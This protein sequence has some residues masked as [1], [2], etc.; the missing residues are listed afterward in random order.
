MKKILLATDGSSCAE[1]AACFLAHLPHDEQLELTVLTVLEIPHTHRSSLTQTWV[2]ECLEQ[3][4]AASAE[5]F[6]QIEEMF[7]GANATLQHVVQEGYR[8]ET[9]VEVAKEADVSLV[10]VGA[11]GHSTV[12]R[13]LLGS[14]SDYVATH[15]HCSVLV[16]RPTGVCKAKRPV[17]L[18]I[19]YAK[20]APAQA[21]L[22]EIAEIPWGKETDVQ[23]ISVVSYLAATFSHIPVDAHLLKNATATAVEEAAE[24]LRDSAP[25]VKTRLLESDHVGEGLV[26][27]AEEHKCD[28]LVVGETPHSALGRVLLGSVSRFVLRHAPCSVWITRNRYMTESKGAQEGAQVTS[29]E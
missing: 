18:A 17:R 22:E 13:L 10:V 19:G 9:I 21:A 5:T 23:I 12:S 6:H 26:K 28:L 2:Q 16:V 3:E 25:N 7:Q 4:K 8:G 27:Y 15:A 14:T 24:Q 20:S 11:R 1:E 29:T